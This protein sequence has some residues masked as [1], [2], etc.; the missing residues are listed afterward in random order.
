MNKFI[1]N[2]N[3]FNESSK[4]DILSD[5]SYILLDLNL[6]VKPDFEQ[7]FKLNMFVSNLKS[8]DELEDIDVVNA[9]LEDIGYKIISFSKD[10]NTN[11]YK[12]LILK[13]SLLSKLEQN[14]ILF[15]KDLNWKKW[16]LADFHKVTENTKQAIIDG[17]C[18][19]IY[20]PI[21]HFSDKNIEIVF[22]DECDVERYYDEVTAEFFLLK[23]Q[24]E[25]KKLVH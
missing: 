13:D 4:Y 14:N 15:W 8:T 7:M 17:V 12:L 23:K 5:I 1:S 6:D 19:I 21:T 20:G 3:N 25:L 11:E 22:Y 24:I 18:S 16:H 10:F 2:F 9:R